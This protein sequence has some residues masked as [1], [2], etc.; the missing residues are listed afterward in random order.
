MYSTLS[1]AA[2]MAAIPAV[3]ALGSAIVENRCDFPV[4]LWSVTDTVGPMQTLEAGD[5]SYSESYRTNADGG[6]VSIKISRDQTQDTITQ[7]EYTLT[8]TLWYDVS[9]INGYPFMDG[10]L[11]LVPSE[12]G[13]PNVLCAA[14]VA[15]CSDAYNIPSDNF[16]TS[17][18]STEANT[19]LVLCSGQ[20]DESTAADAATSVAAA[21][22]AAPVVKAAAV[23]SVAP[24]S[25]APAPVATS[26]TPSSAP[27]AVVA[28]PVALVQ[29]A[30]PQVLTTLATSAAPV[31]S[32]APATT[33]AVFEVPADNSGPQWF[34]HHLAGWIP[35]AK[36][37]SHHPH[38]RHA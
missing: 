6:G 28:T 26:A 3:S 10:G 27:P 33:S 36:R 4:Y 9:N 21:A 35:K 37:H 32:A 5:G 23:S 7:F 11:T 13:C 25:A 22:T 8:S 38:A 18:C 34:G 12:N 30:A 15:A 19:V 20:A 1:A 17:A 31:T 14:G 29:V 16:A 24:T 2:I